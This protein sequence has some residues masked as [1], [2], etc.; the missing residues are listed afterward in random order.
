MEATKIKKEYLQFREKLENDINGSPNLNIS[1]DCYLIE[2]SYIKEFEKNNMDSNLS[3]SSQNVN[4]LKKSPVIINDFTDAINHINSNKQLKLINK[5]L[6]E[7]MG[8][9]NILKSTN[10]VNYYG[11]NKKLIIEYKING[12]KK[13]ILINNYL[14]DKIFKSNI[15]IINR[16]T[17]LYKNIL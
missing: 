11:G 15:F 7:L 2:E 16:S 1:E 4:E 6:F 13:S 5:K 14:K 3:N 17:D 8:L 10:I 12:K 9:K